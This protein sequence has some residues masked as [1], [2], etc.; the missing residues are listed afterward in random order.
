MNLY[1]SE[2]CRQ[3]DQQVIENKN[4]PGLVLMKRAAWC[5]YQ[6]LKTHFPD[7][8]QLAVFCGPGNNGGDGL[9]LAQYASLDGCNVT[10]FT[11]SRHEIYASKL[12]TSARQGWEE[13]TALGLRIE[14]CESITTDTLS[15]F[16]LCVDALLGTGLDR[17][18]EGPMAD[19]IHLINSTSLP[20]MSLDVPSGLD[21]T[22]GHIWTHG[23]QADVTVTF[24]VQKT[25]LVTYLGPSHAG[26]TVLCDLNIEAHHYPDIVALATYHDII[27]W[28]NKRPKRTA[29]FHKGMAGTAWLI[30]G[31]HHMM[32]AILLASHACLKAG[33]GLTKVLSCPEHLVP[34]TSH[35]PELMTYEQ[36]DG[37]PNTQAM[38]IGPGL[39]QNTW[40]L[41]RFEE[42]MTWHWQDPK[43]S[44]VVDADALH[45]LA[46]RP[47]THMQNSHWVLTPHPKEAAYLL[48]T[49]TDAIQTNRFEAV[50]AL[51]RQYGGVIVLKGNGSIIYDGVH[52]EVCPL[53]N[54][55]MAVGGMGDVLTG[56]ICS[57]LAQGMTLFEAACLGVYQ[58]A[59]LAD[60][61]IKTHS[62]HSLTPSDIIQSL[63]LLDNQRRV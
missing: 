2:Q 34:L 63:S 60:Q 8:K 28:Q 16:D 49:T 25:G 1:S 53:G 59:E 41:Q 39:G 44:L 62:L 11:S 10:L 20:V 45:L 52:L 50:K 46:Q 57:Y 58:H 26:K 23:I 33:A 38:A 7:A 12:P 40:A 51:H 18:I 6:L 31:N 27:F 32:G 14:S 15:H 42:A 13:A 56:M 55:G 37:F 5:A 22:T 61:Y 24:I 35:T 47:Q 43:H 36:S 48:N 19:I 29:H 9:F 3:L 21:A 54:A 17:S 30:G 4:L